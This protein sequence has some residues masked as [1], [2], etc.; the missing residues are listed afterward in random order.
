[1]PPKKRSKQTNEKSAKGNEA[2]G[3]GSESRIALDVEKLREAGWMIKQEERQSSSGVKVYL[4]YTNP[5]GK[6]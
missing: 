6:S 3:S 4:H 5:G 2:Q 1:M